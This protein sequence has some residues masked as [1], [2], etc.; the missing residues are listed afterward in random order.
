MDILQRLETYADYC[1]ACDS[2]Q[3]RKDAADEIRQLRHDLAEARR[4]F[5][6]MDAEAASVQ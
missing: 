4:R 3:L 5:D 6:S 1:E 2:R